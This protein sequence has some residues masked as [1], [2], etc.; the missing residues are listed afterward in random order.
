MKEDRIMGKKC[1]IEHMNSH[2]LMPHT[3]EINKDLFKSVKS[4]QSKWEFAREEQQHQKK[5]DIENQKILISKYIEQVKG[6][7]D[8]LKKN[9]QCH[10]V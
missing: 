7:C 4:T 3:I 2:K 10:G 5:T 8:S 1:I 9:Y 6:K